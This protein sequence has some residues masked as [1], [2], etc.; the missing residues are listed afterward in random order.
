VTILEWEKALFGDKFIKKSRIER[1][2]AKL[3][4]VI[5]KGKK[6]LEEKVRVKPI[7][8]EAM[9]RVMGITIEELSRDISE[10]LIRSPIIDFDIDI[11][12]S[13]KEAKK[14]FV[15]RYLKK[16]LEINYGN[17]SEV[18][19]ITDLDR[20]SIHRIV[21]ESEI[22]VDNIR[23]KMAKAYEIK[24]S[25]VNAIVED[26]LDNYKAVIHPVKLDEM[27]K[28]VSEFSKDIIESLPEKQATLKEAEDEFEKEFIKKALRHN[29]RNITKTAKEIGIR[30]ETLHR[31]IKKWGL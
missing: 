9:H 18:A 6:K 30:Y 21:K 13:F 26:V 16:L 31:K 22:N 4:K 10:K 12:M 1:I 25:A 14:Q 8:D 5:E 29:Q 3:E 15:K 17:V 20:R 11:K 28:N 19:K 23:K 24:Q 2:M 27:Y 7:I